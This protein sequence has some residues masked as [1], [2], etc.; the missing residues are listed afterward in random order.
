[1]KKQS[2]D[3]QVGSYLRTTFRKGRGLAKRLP[4]RLVFVAALCGTGDVKEVRADGAKL[5]N[6]AS[7][8]GLNFRGI[9]IVQPKGIVP[10]AFAVDDNG[11]RWSAME[12]PNSDKV[13][14]NEAH[15]RSIEDNNAND[16]IMSSKEEFSFTR[17][18]RK[19]QPS[20]V[21]P[22]GIVGPCFEHVAYAKRHE[23]VLFPNPV[24][25]LNRG[26]M[27]NSLGPASNSHNGQWAVADVLIG[28]L[29]SVKCSSVPTIPIGKNAAFTADLHMDAAA[30][31]SVGR[32]RGLGGPLSGFIGFPT[33]GNSL[34]SLA[35]L[36]LYE[37]E[38]NGYANKPK[39]SE[40]A[41]WVP[42]EFTFP[43]PP[44][45]VLLL[46]VAVAITM[47]IVVNPRP[48]AKKNQGKRDR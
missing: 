35:D 11:L 1:M 48:K 34:F 6:P 9:A 40:K 24:T 43:P 44:L 29:K 27:G 8:D 28:E 21:R 45:T 13:L 10:H 16:E 7:S 15:R 32:L 18:D 20:V 36:G 4:L 3:S 25:F 26:A 46:A 33:E 47:V 12:A 39:N 23:D 42:Y 38:A 14:K 30:G 17:R 19:A 41:G 5:R 2:P 37:Q 31:F 22:A